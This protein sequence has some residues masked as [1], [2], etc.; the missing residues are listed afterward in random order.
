MLDY[1]ILVSNLW[2]WVVAVRKRL[3]VQTDHQ[4]SNDNGLP[5]CDSKSLEPTCHLLNSEAS[6]A[7]ELAMAVIGHNGPCSL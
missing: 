1:N 5:G 3:L 2:I 6:P 4:W 7:L